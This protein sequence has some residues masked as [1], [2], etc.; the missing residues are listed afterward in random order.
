MSIGATLNE[1]CPLMLCCGTYAFFADSAL[2]LKAGKAGNIDFG[3][4][5][6]ISKKHLT[7]PTKSVIL[8][9]T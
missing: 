6:K 3:K 5:E 7:K 8:F 2:S 1:R 9:S 4:I